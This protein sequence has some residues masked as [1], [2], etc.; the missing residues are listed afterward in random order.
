MDLDLREA[1][2]NNGTRK[3]SVRERRSLRRAGTLDAWFSAR[4]KHADFRR[5]PCC[6]LVCA[7][8]RTARQQSFDPAAFSLRWAEDATV[9]EIRFGWHARSAIRSRS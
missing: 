3:T 4:V 1:R 9:S 6:R 8:N 2:G 5:F 7:C